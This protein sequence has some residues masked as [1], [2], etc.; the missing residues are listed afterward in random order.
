VN[1]ETRQQL[2]RLASTAGLST[3]DFKVACATLAGYVELPAIMALT[4]VKRDRAT[5][6]AQNVQIVLRTKGLTTITGA[7]NV[8]QAPSRLI[9]DRLNSKLGLKGWTPKQLGTAKEL[10]SETLDRLQ[11]NHT[12]TLQVIFDVIDASVEHTS[13]ARSTYPIGFLK[14]YLMTQYWLALPSEKP[15]EVWE[16]EQQTGKR[17]KFDFIDR[18]WNRT[19]E[20]LV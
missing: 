20:A 1:D 4:R 7:Q 8:Q 12:A 9:L 11:G 15:L 6:A 14:Q 2:I 10:Y 3:N 13:F 17:M 5:K 19:Q 16:T 18:Y